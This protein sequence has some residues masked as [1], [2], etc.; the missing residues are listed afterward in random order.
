MPNQ[1]VSQLTVPDD[2]N[3]STVTYTTYDI[4]DEWAR[5]TINNDILPV[6]EGGMHYVGVATDTISD[7]STT[8]P[9]HIQGKTDPVTVTSG[10]IVTQGNKEYVWDGAAW[11]EFGDMSALGDFAYVDTGYVTVTP[12][13]TVSKPSF[14]GSSTNVSFTITKPSSGTNYTPEGTNSAPTFTGTQATITPTITATKVTS[15]TPTIQ[16]SG[17]VSQPTFSNGAASVSATYTPGG[18]ISASFSGTQATISSTG[19]ATGT[20]SKPTFT[21]DKFNL[22]N[23]NGT[24]ST[25]D[26]ISVATD[27]TSN[28]TATVSAASSGTTTYTPAGTI[29]GTAITVSKKDVG[30]ILT[31]GSKA[32]LQTTY[33]AASEDLKL[34]FTPNTLPTKETVS[35]VWYGNPTITQPT[36]SGTAVRLVTGNIPVPATYSV[37]ITRTDKTHTHTITATKV[38]TGTPTIQLSGSVSQ[39]TFSNGAVTA[40]ATYTPAGTVSATFTG[41]EATISSTGTA[42]GT[43]SKPTFTGDKF[44]LTASATYTPAGTVSA[45]T[46]TGTAVKIA[47]SVTAAGSVS[48]PT[49]TGTAE[50]WTVYPGTPTP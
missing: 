43:V 27:T 11:R 36:F 2:T 23:D 38:T 4:K 19:T 40:S 32:R 21:G 30:S 8:N 25:I 13:G 34:T 20:V 48:Q 46:F 29:S 49:F 44:N 28:K 6:L 37:D 10:D 35:N 1:L 14:T 16:L 50:T 39:P 47:G 26:S 3:A 41:T 33:T 15:G 31:T 24:V 45:P 18:T 5:D 22:T 9:V 12:H 42:T 17:T 7:G